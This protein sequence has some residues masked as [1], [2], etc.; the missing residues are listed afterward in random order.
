MFERMSTWS[1][2]PPCALG[3]S[4]DRFTMDVDALIEEGQ[5]HVEV[6]VAEI[7]R[8]RGWP[9]RWLNDDVEA[10]IPY[11]KDRKARTVYEDTYLVVTAASAEHLLAMKVHAGRAKDRDDIYFLVARL[12]FASAGEVFDLHDEVLPHDPP[13]RA[14]FERACRILLDLWPQDR[15]LK[16]DDRYGHGAPRFR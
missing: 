9:D 10:V 16:H 5:G 3:F 11:S 2:G 13:K 4:N 15:S 1:V 7:A 12:N 8:R 14:N 6:A